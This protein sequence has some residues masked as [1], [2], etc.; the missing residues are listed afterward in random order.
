MSSLGGGEGGRGGGRRLGR[1]KGVT[2]AFNRRPPPLD[3][4]ASGDRSN[5]FSHIASGCLISVKEYKGM[6]YITTE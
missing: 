6:Y 4:S 2:A 1:P 3:V 5:L